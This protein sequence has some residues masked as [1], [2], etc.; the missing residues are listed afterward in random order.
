MKKIILLGGSKQQIP[1]IIKAKELNLYTVLVDYLED[2]P[3]Q[4][5][6]D[7][8]YCESTVN[9]EK[10]L[11]IAKKENIDGIL[12]YASDPAAPTAAY[13]SEK[14]NLPTNSFS[15]VQ[16]LT[17]KGEFR[18]F[19]TDNN[20]NCPS[21]IVSNSYYSI[22]DNINSLSLPLIIK[23]VDS[24]GSKGV[25]RIDNYF[26]IEK[27]FEY[28]LEFS[29]VK[30]VVIE[31]FIEKEH[32]YLVGGDIFVVNGEIIFWG[33]LNCHRSE[34]VTPLIP[35]GKSYP[36]LIEDDKIQLIQNELTLLIKK[37]NIEFGAF[38]VEI[39]VGKDNKVYVIELGPRNGGNFIPDFL[40]IIFDIDMITLSIEFAI[41]IKTNVMSG[42]VKSGYFLS[43]N[44]HSIKNGIL[45]KIKLDNTLEDK[46]ISRF[47]NIDEG[48][49]VHKFDGANKVV[50]IIFLKFSNYSE[51][52][53]VI[54]DPYK[55]IEVVVD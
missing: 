43:F 10:V 28:A 26:D 31:E 14:L 12:A 39:I 55:F 33:L 54:R 17:D 18:R 6:A 42:N 46:I 51:W 35:I 29:K 25:T 24:S 1:A 48:Q 20:F 44:V 45:R 9:K 34:I 4:I 41:D 49:I 21:S 16:I 15:T 13:V 37:L 50:E 30:R 3:G 8:F 40:K 36:L 32:E 22:K 52:I 27:A 5:Y 23:P 19:L 53:D 7:K 11:E 38:N 47:P 2:N